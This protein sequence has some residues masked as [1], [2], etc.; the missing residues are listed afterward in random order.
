MVD[1]VVPLAPILRVELQLHWGRLAACLARRGLLVYAWSRTSLPATSPHR[2]QRGKNK[3]GDMWLITAREISEP[4]EASS[5]SAIEQIADSPIR[6]WEVRHHGHERAGPG[7]TSGGPRHR[8]QPSAQQRVK[9]L[10][11]LSEPAARLIVT[12]K[13]L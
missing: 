12:P 6:S 3:I 11:P 1:V 9:G 8:L 7:P 5:P 10:S 13:H 2:R 4:T